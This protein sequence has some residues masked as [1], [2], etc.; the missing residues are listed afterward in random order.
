MGNDW[1]LE[2]HGHISL[3]SLQIKTNR[4]IGEFFT[5]SIKSYKIYEFLS[6]M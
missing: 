6:I 1:Q 3:F 2:F 4:I 5:L